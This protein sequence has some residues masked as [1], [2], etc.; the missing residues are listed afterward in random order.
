MNFENT[1]PP[2]IADLKIL[3][4]YNHFN[5]MRKPPQQEGTGGVSPYNA[6]RFC[7]GG[8]SFHPDWHFREVRAAR[9]VRSSSSGGMSEVYF[10]TAFI[11]NGWREITGSRLVEEKKILDYKNFTHAGLKENVDIHEKL[12]KLKDPIDLA[13]IN[14]FS[15]NI[16]APLVLHVIEIFN[17]NIKVDG[18]VVNDNAEHDFMVYKKKSLNSF[19][20]LTL[21]VEHFTALGGRN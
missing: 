1:Y 7:G 8:Y 16:E 6:E 2:P 4:T 13:L 21:T 15:Q 10:E 3:Y 5:S 11:C 19:I 20:F 12:K 18:Y 14:F 9:A 17:R